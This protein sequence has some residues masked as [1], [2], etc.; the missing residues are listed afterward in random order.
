MNRL[1]CNYPYP[2]LIPGGEDYLGCDFSINIDSDLERK[3]GVLKIVLSYNLKC[4]GL[5]DM[6]INKE[7]DVCVQIISRLTSYREVKKF[8]GNEKLTLSIDPT[9][10]SKEIIF[11]P[12]IIALKDIDNFK[13]PEHN[14]IFKDSV[15]NIKKGEKIGFANSFTYTLPTVDPLRPTSSIVRIKLN[16]SPKAPPYEINLDSDKIVI[17]LNE[18]AFNLYK[19]L[20]TNSDINSFLSPII[21]L[22]TIVE[23]LTYLKFNDLDGT[24]QQSTWGT[25]LLNVLKKKNIDLATTNKSLVTIANDVFNDGFTFALN[26]MKNFYDNEAGVE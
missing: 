21:M 15:I 9:L 13:L 24:Y 8:N 26:S 12:F 6:I 25:V 16:N 3:S 19:E 20:R 4:D 11:I 5:T 10:I 18:N 23:A 7:V 17:Y 2:V 1:D 14:D 22:P